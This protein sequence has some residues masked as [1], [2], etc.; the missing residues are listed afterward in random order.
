LLQ[1]LST[2]RLPE[3]AHLILEALTR[4]E[5]A[6]KRGDESDVET[7]AHRTLGEIRRAGGVK[8]AAWLAYLDAHVRLTYVADAI[9]LELVVLPTLIGLKRALRRFGPSPQLHL[10]LA[11]AH[12]RLGQLS[13]AVD[14]LGRAVYYSNGDPFFLRLVL[15]SEFVERTRPR[16]RQ[17]CRELLEGVTPEATPEATS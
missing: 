16:L 8:H 14:E 7:E 2:D 17:Q 6:R 11:H 5:A 1:R 15:D 12:A 9:N 3:E 13:A 10:A 4:T